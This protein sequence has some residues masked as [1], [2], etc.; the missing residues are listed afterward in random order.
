MFGFGL[1]LLSVLSGLLALTGHAVWGEAALSP[2]PGNGLA[3]AGA[4]LLAAAIVAIPEEL[5]F[6]G[7]VVSYLRWS[8]SALVSIG[9]VVASALI[10]AV[11]HNL[12][13]PLAWLTA[14]DL[15]LFVGLFLLGVLLATAYLATRSLWC[16]IG[17]HAALVAFDRA[18]LQTELISIDLSPW[19]LGGGTDDV[20]EAPLVWLSFVVA[21][22]ALIASRRWLARHLAIETPFVGV[23]TSPPT[24]PSSPPHS[25]LV[26][27]LGA[28]GLEN[29]SAPPDGWRGR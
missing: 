3:A 8:T 24:T 4:S 6:R 5:L 18:V 11:A 12:D 29:V 16:P 23:L 27:R 2:Q 14:A 1:A 20:R 9:A 15:P 10:F 19:W 13:D 17:L 21:S 25:D 7:F 22:F 28:T 26:P